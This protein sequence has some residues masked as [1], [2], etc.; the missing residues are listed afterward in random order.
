MEAKRT[1]MET[2]ANSSK[3]ADYSTNA[4]PMNVLPV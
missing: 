3:K 4:R 1:A 2:L